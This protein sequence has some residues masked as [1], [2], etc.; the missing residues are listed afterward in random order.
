MKRLSNDEL[1]QVV[2]GINLNNSLINA[3]SRIIS[4]ILDVGRSLGT[5]I[6]RI[7]EDN[8]CELE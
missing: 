3:F 8:I 5:S 7:G 4:V 1:K 2:G 6:R